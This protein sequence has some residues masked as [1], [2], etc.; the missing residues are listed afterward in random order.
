[1][2]GRETRAPERATYSAC[3]QPV[4]RKSPLEVSPVAVGHEL[5]PTLN[6]GIDQRV[7]FS[8]L[9]EDETGP[10]ALSG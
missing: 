5:P 3:A 7:I 2:V 8:R 9:I 6:P 10:K 4:Q 1:M